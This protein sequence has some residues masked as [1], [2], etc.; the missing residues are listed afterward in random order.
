MY[1]ADPQTLA[2][3]LKLVRT[4]RESSNVII[5][6]PRDKTLLAVQEFT[7]SGLPVAPLGQV[8]ADLLTLPGRFAQEADQLIDHLGRTDPDWSE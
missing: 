8:L 4:G 7:A 2:D 3:Q 5:T 1:A 6:T